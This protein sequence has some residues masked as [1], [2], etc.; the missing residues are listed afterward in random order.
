MELFGIP[1]N[2]LLTYE[3][4]GAQ[5]ESLVLTFG[6][7]VFFIIVFKIFR[8]VVLARISKL[9][10]KT[11]SLFDDKLA[12]V[13][14]EVSAAFYWFLAFYLAT[15]F[16]PVL[17]DEIKK[18]FDGAFIVIIVYEVIKMAQAIIDFALDNWNKSERK[19]LD[20]TTLHALNMVISIVLWVTGILLVLSNLGF[21]ISALVASLGVGGIAV[22]L[23]AQNILGDLFSSF[24]I[25]ID[26][27]FQVGDFIVLGTDKGIVKKIG[28]K[29]TRIQ[30][31]Q[32]EELVVSNKELTTARVQNFK[33]MKR[34]RIGFSFGVTYDTPVKKME[35]IPGM[36]K[37]IIDALEL[38][39]CDRVHFH[40]FG[41]S[42]LLFDIIYYIN[43]HDYTDYMNAQ[44]EINLEIMRQFEK[45]KIEMAY[46]TQ[47]VYLK[48]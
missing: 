8:R 48:K 29:T 45:E 34:R 15:K 26:R 3:V 12:E 35:K 31:L 23:A 2:E 5:L 20:P 46:P 13:F 1:F 37:S 4:F 17:T 28:L 18:V 33:K 6:C 25:Y 30:T 44:Q 21:N 24:S 40:A 47:T 41:D 38:A 9:A 16:S 11:S 10:K 14:E 32:G 39:E 27:P 22:A 42:A 7:F 19:G 36:I 43:S